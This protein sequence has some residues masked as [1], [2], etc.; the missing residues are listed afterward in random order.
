[1]K[2]I[3]LSNWGLNEGTLKEYTES[4]SDYTLG[5]V[6]EEHKG[7][8]KIITEEGK[9]LGQVSGKYLYNSIKRVDYP[10]VGDWVALDSATDKN[11]VSIIQGLL[12]RKSKFSRKMAGKNNDEQIIATNIDTIFICMALNSDFNLKRLDRYISLAWS[13]GATPVVILTKCDLCDD[14]IKKVELVEETALG[15]AI[16]E[17][18]TYSNIGLEEVKKY[19][20]YGKTVGFVGSSGVGKS[21][22]INY[23]LGYEKQEINGTRNDDKGRHT[24][25]YR[26]M[27]AIPQGGVVI[28]TPGMREI[29]VLD[30][31]GGI[32]SSFADIE[33]LSKDCRFVDCH[34]ME[35]PHCAVRNA[36]DQGELSKERFENYLKLK[37]EAEYMERKSDK[38]A[39]SDYRKKIAKRNKSRSNNIY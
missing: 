22:L 1:M 29:H 39:E 9:V 4:Y 17:V 19:V 18:S 6:I 33:G 26:K 27:I 8:Y 21:T 38:K 12:T 36:I 5:R 11:S 2:N 20:E 14:I 13:S 37:K 3:N 31:T 23:L 30:D 24:T 28:D 16:I 34:H 10:G 35:E 7:I 25:T 15:I 32:D